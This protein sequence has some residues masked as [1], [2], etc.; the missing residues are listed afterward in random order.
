MLVSTRTR[1]AV[2][3]YRDRADRAVVRWRARGLP[4]RHSAKLRTAGAR[5]A[6]ELLM[7]G[8]AGQVVAVGEVADRD[9]VERMCALLRH[10]GPDSEGIYADGNAVLGV[11]RLAIIDVRHG[12][13]PIYNE[14]RTVVVVLNGEIYNF[15]E[16]RRRLEQR[17]HRFATGADT[18]V[19]VHLY[20]ESGPRLVDDLRGMFA[21]ALWDSRNQRLLLARDRVGKKP[22]YY[23]HEDGRLSFAS[24]LAALLEDP[25]IPR[26]VDP[27]AI[28]AYLGLLYVPDPLCAIEGVRKLQ[29]A[30]RLVW[31]AGEVEIDRYW[32]LEFLRTD[33]VSLGEA[34]ERI[35]SHLDEAVRIRL[36]SE[37]PLGAFLSGGVDS[38]AVVATMAEASSSPVK[39]FSVGFASDRFNELPYARRIAE[40]FSTDHTEVV[41]EADAVAV[42]P[43]LINHYGDPFGDS[44]AIPSYYV[45]EVASRDVTVALN[46][47]GGDES[48]GGYNRYVATVL[49]DHL[50][51]LPRALRSAA[52]R[53]ASATPEPRAPDSA[54]ARARRMAVALS[55]APDRRYAMRMTY[56]SPE[57]RQ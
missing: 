42:L 48:F 25:S 15:A 41:V 10:R 24:E 36:L 46:G 17:G 3:N 52:G 51:I 8:I 26:R 7:C 37:R 12:D 34:A 4:L 18:E 31:D 2:E 9:A 20:E 54:W 6:S 16:L 1:T 57:V 55:L 38:A 30:S 43:K 39:T 33:A 32:R 28:D 40:L 35:R 5:R 45:A 14:D 27:Q 22:L 19:I 50:D 21:F 11:R 23:W 47:D 53:V 29:P 13:Q 49:G 56:C 44:S